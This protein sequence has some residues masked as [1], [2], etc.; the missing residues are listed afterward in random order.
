M[1]TGLSRPTRASRALLG[2]LLGLAIVGAPGVA[3]ATDPTATAI[4]G[5]VR[6]PAAGCAQSTLGGLSLPQRVGQL[7]MVGI[8]STLDA[9]ERSLIRDAHIGSVTFAAR[10]TAGRPFVAAQTAAVRAL[11]TAATTDGVGFLVAANQEGGTVQALAGSGFST[12][13]SAVAQGKL[14]VATHRARAR[15]W[16]S[17]LRKA[18]VN[19]DLAPVGDIVPKAWKSINQPIGRL[20]REFGRGPAVVARHVGSFIAGMAE[21]RVLTAV[22]HFPGL[23]RVTGNTDFVARVKDAMTTRDDPF[24]APFRRAVNEDVAFVMIS[25]AEYTRIDPGTLAA[26]SRPIVTGM[27]RGD[28][29]FDGVVMS[30]DLSAAAVRGIKPGTRAIRWIK[31]GGDLIITT[32]LADTRTMVATLVA[33]AKARP[34]FRDRIDRAALRVLQAKARMGL[35]PC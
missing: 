20:D 34:A 7:F 18:G 8:G 24:L 33:Q 35:L 25:L 29:G 23:G 10:I 30:D 31:A 26:F 32:G 3:T 15:S 6:V 22:K 14:D 1:G 12:I 19:V 27:L 28:L 17:E 21:A 13:P 4:P 11:A 5:A 9:A 16:G 2:A